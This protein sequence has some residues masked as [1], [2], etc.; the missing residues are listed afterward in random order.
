MRLETLLTM[1]IKMDSNVIFLVGLTCGAKNLN[2]FS[3]LSPKSIKR[4]AHF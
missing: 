1:S 2:V 3:E 4:A